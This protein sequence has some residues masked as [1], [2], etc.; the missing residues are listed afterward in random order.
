MNCSKKKK[1]KKNMDNR[2]LELLEKNCIRGSD[3]ENPTFFTIEPREKYR[4]LSENTSSFWSGYLDLF[5][6]GAKMNLCEVLPPVFPLMIKA[7]LSF[8]MSRNPIEYVPEDVFLFLIDKYQQAIIE[9]LEV[10]D[11][12][13]ELFCCV[14]E[15]EFMT[16]FHGTVFTSFILF[17]P[18]CR[19]DI[20]TQKNLIRNTVLSNLK[21]SELSKLFPRLP[22]ESDWS[23]ILDETFPSNS[24]PFPMYGSRLKSTS[25]PYELKRIYADVHTNKQEISLEEI[26]IPQNSYIYTAKLFSEEPDVFHQLP[27]LFSFGYCINRITIRKKEQTAEKYLSVLSNSDNL[28]KKENSEIE[29]ASEFLSM[30]SEGRASDE[31]SWRDIGKALYTVTKGS[32]SGLHMW[33]RFSANSD[34]F[35]P[36]D[37]EIEYPSFHENQFTYKTLS[38][39]AREDSPEKWNRWHKSWV[40]GSIKEALSGNHSDVAECFFR[41]YFMDFA[42]SRIEPA[43]WFYFVSH[44]WR[45]IDGAHKIMNIIPTSFT[46]I[47]EFYRLTIIQESYSSTDENLKQQI[48]VMTRKVGILIS[49]LKNFPY[50][51]NILGVLRYRFHI[52]NWD[53]FVDKSPSLFSVYNGVIECC[54]NRAI[55]RKGKPEDFLTRFSPVRYNPNYNWENEDVKTAMQWFTDCFE[56]EAVRDYFL[57]FMSSC[58]ESGNSDKIFAVFTG[59]SDNSKSAIKIAFESVFGSTSFTFTSS[60]ITSKKSKSDPKTADPQLSFASLS[61]VSWLQEPSKSDEIDD[62]KLKELV[63]MDTT[64]ARTLHSSGGNFRISFKLILLC[65]SVPRILDADKAILTRLVI[66]PFVARF[67]RPGNPEIPVTIEEQR[68]KKI[69]PQ[70]ARFESKVIPKLL[71][72]ILWILVSYFEKYRQ[73]GLN[74][75]KEIRRATD[76]YWKEKDIYTSFISDCFESYTLQDGSPDPTKKISIGDV[77]TLFKS[78]Y[79][80]NYPQ[81]KIPM[82]DTVISEMTNRWGKHIG[83]IWFGHEPKSCGV[84]I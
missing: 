45:E 15:P 79:R 66:V 75:P 9:C 11:D 80:E 26:F 68:K 69:F 16:P 74:I 71:S 67:L 41:K 64:Y 56:S 57:R 43:R 29:L 38:W 60:Y 47:F 40:D 37:C 73:E 81:M 1:E 65:N 24:N 55:F 44:Q 63:S 58:I 18:Y 49:K 51:K 77:Y 76:T 28:E 82:R 52:E 53:T 48:E 83:K 3:V 70:I 19:L 84:Y 6:D 14:L 39:Y 4:L 33:K 62:G 7:N 17:F 27:L 72:P 8:S 54:S 34:E 59:S 50:M 13:A 10:S 36:E 78:W 22:R 61:K 5:E 12:N 2:F 31:S 32:D 25:A 23:T 21:T 42:C 46:K 20:T 35:S 30:I